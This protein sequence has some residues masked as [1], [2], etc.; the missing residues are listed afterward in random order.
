M[1]VTRPE[2]IANYALFNSVNEVEPQTIEAEDQNYRNDGNSVDV[3]SEMAQ[4]AKNTEHYIAL[5]NFGSR[6]D[7]TLKS[8][9]TSGGT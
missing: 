6:L 2:H 8:V 7:K 9:I 4:L 5:N 3:E 1:R